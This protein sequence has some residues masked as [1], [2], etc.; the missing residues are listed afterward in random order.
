M[1]TQELNKMTILELLKIQ[2]LQNETIIELL[3][4]NSNA[5]NNNT[6]GLEETKAKRGKARKKSD[7][8]EDTQAESL[9]KQEV[10]ET[11]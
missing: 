10:E 7:R 5:D 11:A 2:V 8:D 9:P 6:Q 1:N 3:K 4:N